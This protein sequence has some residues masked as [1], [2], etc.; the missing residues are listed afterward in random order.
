MSVGVDNDGWV[1]VV[2]GLYHGQQVHVQFGDADAARAF[3]TSVENCAGDL[4]VLV[5]QDWADVWLRPSDVA[6]IS[7]PLEV[8]PPGLPP[9][10]RPSYGRRKR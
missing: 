1:R 8:R 2:L 9:R 4:V 6:T 7:A 3:L 5:G 10:S